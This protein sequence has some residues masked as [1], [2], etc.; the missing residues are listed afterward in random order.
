MT[1][2]NEKIY[3]LDKVINGNGQPGIDQ[4]V[5][6]IIASLAEQ[7]GASQASN[8]MRKRIIWVVGVVGTA[9]C[10]VAGWG[11]HKAWDSLE[12]P[13]AAI[14]EDYWAHHPQSRVK[15]PEVTTGDN[16]PAQAKTNKNLGTIP[17]RNGVNG[18]D[19]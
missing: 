7:R 15:P 16:E 4:K 11:L 14:V 5:D 3:N 17:N 9:L 18:Y 6:A 10:S 12:P 19:F 13:A 1:S 8:D 2:L